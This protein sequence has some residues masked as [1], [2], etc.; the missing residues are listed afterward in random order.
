MAPNSALMRPRHPAAVRAFNYA[1]RLLEKSGL[2]RLPLDE[3]ML[4]ETARRRAGSG[5]FEDESFREPLQHLLDSLNSESRLNLVGKLAARHDVLQILTNRLLIERDRREHPEIGARPIVRP[6]FIIGM[7]RT[8]TTLLHALLAQDSDHRSPLTWE[9]MFPSPPTGG[10]EKRRVRRAEKEMAWLERIAPDFKLVHLADARLPQECIAIMSHTFMSDQFDVMFNVPGYRTWLEQ[11]E[12]RPVYAY[13]RLFLQHLQHRLPARRWV[14]KAPSH[15]LALES[16]LA[17]YPDANIVQTHREPLE[18]L[19]STASLT[20]LLR[21]TFSDSVDPATIGHEMSL[22]WADALE[23][24]MRVRKNKPPEQFLDIHFTELLQE[25][26]AA[27][28]RL[29][30]HF[31][32]PL[33]REAEERMRRLLAANPRDKHG[34]HHYSLAQFGLDATKESPRFDGYRACFNLVPT[35]A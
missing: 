30:A 15:M 20:T 25:P 17:I 8:G 34:P 31:G 4:L 9:V 2:L 10:D 24:F 35:A 23:Q 28:R 21:S 1:G 33:S 32:D 22:F 14:L 6:L 5:D 16:L 18:V 3:G 11:Q 26:I 19:A 27:V 13:H 7:P 29:Y 12:M